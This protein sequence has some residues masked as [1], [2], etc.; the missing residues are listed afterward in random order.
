MDLPGVTIHPFALFSHEHRPPQGTVLRMLR[1]SGLLVL[2][3]CSWFEQMD[4]AHL[5]KTGSS[6]TVC[7]KTHG[8]RSLDPVSFYPDPTILSEE[9]T[10]SGSALRF[11]DLNSTRDGQL[12]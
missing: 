9:V 1:N 3:W 2:A 4:T 10:F 7:I 8:Q 5:G 6:I 12:G 11:R